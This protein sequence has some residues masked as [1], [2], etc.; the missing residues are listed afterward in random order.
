MHPASPTPCNPACRPRCSTTAPRPHLAASCRCPAGQRAARLRASWPPAAQTC[1]CSLGTPRT[2]AVRRKWGGWV[3]SRGRG[4]AR[5]Q[6]GIHKRHVDVLPAHIAG[7]APASPPNRWQPTITHPHMSGWSVMPHTMPHTS[8]SSLLAASI[9]ATSAK[10]VVG[11]S[12]PLR[13]GLR[14]LLV[15]WQVGRTG[16]NEQWQRLDS[17]RQLP[18]PHSRLHASAHS[19]TSNHRHATRAPAPSSRE[20]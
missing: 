6:V 1:C 2:A 10:V 16:E 7:A 20:L 5:E 17:V 11:T 9:P 8:A 18:L 13:L 19:L 15:H 3:L 14:F 4:S 12:L